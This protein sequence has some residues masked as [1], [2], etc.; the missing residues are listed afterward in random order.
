MNWKGETSDPPPVRKEL[1]FKPCS[2]KDMKEQGNSRMYH[3]S[4]QVQ[5]NARPSDQEADLSLAVD[6]NVCLVHS[7]VFFPGSLKE[8]LFW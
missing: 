2:Q 5:G 1:E 7:T 8:K 4:I 6:Q 3:I